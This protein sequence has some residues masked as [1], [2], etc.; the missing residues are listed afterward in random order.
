MILPVA[1]TVSILKHRVST[2]SGWE[3]LHERTAKDVSSCPR[4]HKSSME[5]MDRGIPKNQVALI[6]ELVFV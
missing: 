6:A 2:R 1:L 5:E 4:K 3:I